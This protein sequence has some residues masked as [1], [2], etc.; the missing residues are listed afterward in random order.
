MLPP[1]K[2]QTQKAGVRDKVNLGCPSGKLMEK[3]SKFPSISGVQLDLNDCYKTF[4]FGKS[5]YS[6]SLH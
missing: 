3:K 2:E 1:K 5:L 4:S 6:L